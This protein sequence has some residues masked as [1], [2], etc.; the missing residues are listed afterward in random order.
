MDGTQPGK[1]KMR[2][3]RLLALLSVAL[4]PAA[5]AGAESVS[6]RTTVVDGDSL[7]V[8]G[9]QIRIWGIDAPEMS[10]RAG[11]RAKRYLR[12][13]IAENAVRCEDNGLRI[14]GQIM[15]QCFLGT[16]DLGRVMVLSGN[17]RDW[18]RYSRG[19]Y[20]HAL[21]K[22]G[23]PV[24]RRPQVARRRPVRAPTRPIVRSARPARRASRA[25]REAPIFTFPA[26]PSSAP[27]AARPAARPP[28]ARLPAARLPATE[29]PP[30]TAAPRKSVSEPLR[31]TPPPMAEHQPQPAVVDEDQAETPSRP[32]RIQDE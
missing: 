32:Q 17:A 7:V 26:V 31:L 19:Y 2:Y 21:Q 28:V 13:L 3:L 16:V 12:D 6:G 18:Q 30:V 22:A 15:A 1:S 4:L 24:R 10:R 11:V 5:P 23:L 27:P 25:S 9:R 20:R 8:A 29:Y 14:G